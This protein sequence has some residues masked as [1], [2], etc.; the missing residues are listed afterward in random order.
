[1]LYFKLILLFKFLLT[2][3]D[4]NNEYKVNKDLMIKS[5]FLRD[6]KVA[7]TDINERSDCF[8][9]LCLTFS[10][11][12]H[13]I[14]AFLDILFDNNYEITEDLEIILTFI[15]FADFLNLYAD[16]HDK[17]IEFTLNSLSLHIISNRFV[18]FDDEKIFKEDDFL[19]TNV[20]EELND[21]L[22]VR[23]LKYN[24]TF[25]FILDSENTHK[26]VTIHFLKKTQ[27]LKIVNLNLHFST[28]KKNF[29]KQKL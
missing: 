8:E 13:H 11:K 2:A 14:N 17:I 28:I 12:K 26:N 7:F 23:T 4:S 24:F 1:M 3:E 21:K 25:E 10:N 16:S 27:T 19:F 15:K 29:K 18:F 5:I 20:C 22:V 9:A 6:L